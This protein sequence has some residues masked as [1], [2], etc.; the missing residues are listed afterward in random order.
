MPETVL[1]FDD[2]CAQLIADFQHAMDDNSPVTLPLM[3][4]LKSLLEEG[5]NAHADRDALRTKGASVSSSAKTA[6][7]LAGQLVAAIAQIP[8]D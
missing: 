7:S 2:R 6:A 3:S 1:S 8:K 5:C 4:E